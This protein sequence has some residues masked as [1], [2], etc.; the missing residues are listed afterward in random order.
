MTDLGGWAGSQGVHVLAHT[1]QDDVWYVILFYESQ[2][3]G[4]QPLVRLSSH[5]LNRDAM[6]DL[7]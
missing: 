3:K 1:P 7:T 5:R 4:S 6:A 2:E